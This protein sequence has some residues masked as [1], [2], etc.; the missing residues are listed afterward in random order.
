MTAA[1]ATAA[2]WDAATGEQVAAYKWGKVAGRLGTVAVLPDGL[3]A[4]AGGTRGRLVRWDLP[5]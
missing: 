4:V 1:G 3:T 2:V 5:G